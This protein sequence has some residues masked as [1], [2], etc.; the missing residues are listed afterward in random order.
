M[1]FDKRLFCEDIQINWKDI[2]K[3]DVV[4]QG[5]ED[6]KYR[7]LTDVSGTYWEYFDINDG[8]YHGLSPDYCHWLV[9]GQKCVGGK[10]IKI[11]QN[12]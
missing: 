10:L 3:G 6:Y 7:V 11:V 1:E 4:L 9:I 5:S 12:D 2:K 8:Y